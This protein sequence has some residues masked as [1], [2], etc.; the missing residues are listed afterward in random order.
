MKKV[1]ALLFLLSSLCFGS[2][3]ESYEDI[4]FYECVSIL[5]KLGKYHL[6]LSYKIIPYGIYHYIG[7]T[8]KVEKFNLIVEIEK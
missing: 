3:F 5:E 8:N 2:K 4:S 6:I 7:G 1:L